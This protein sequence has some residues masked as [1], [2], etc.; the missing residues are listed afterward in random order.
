V[1]VGLAGLGDWGKN[2]VRN[3]SELAD[4]RW[5]CDVDPEALERF[6][7]RHPGVRTTGDFEELL[8]DPG[9]DAVVIALVLMPGHLPSTTP[10]SA[11][12]RI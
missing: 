2:L 1:K 8:A 5:L 9:L 4:L 11:S 6:A 7:A 3:F 12:S 10:A